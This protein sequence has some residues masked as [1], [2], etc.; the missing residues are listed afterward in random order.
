MDSPSGLRA[1]P[2]LA[3]RS[4]GVLQT[5]SSAENYLDSAHSV[6][7]ERP[8]WVSGVGASALV[9]IELGSRASTDFWAEPRHLS[10]RTSPGALFR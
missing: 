4:Q 3:H 10:D 8:L 9:A 7:G 5:G 1:A 2:A 6:R